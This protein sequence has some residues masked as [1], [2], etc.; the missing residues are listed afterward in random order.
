MFNRTSVTSRRVILGLVS[1][2]VVLVVAMAGFVAFSPKAEI[3]RYDVDSNNVALNGYDTVAYFVDGKATK[4]K[5][6]FEHLWQDAR[7]HF[8]NATNRDMFSANPNRFAPQYGG[9]CSVGLA[10]GEYS[11]ANPEAWSIVDGKLYL[12]KAKTKEIKAKVARL[13]AGKD[14]YIRSADYNWSKNRDQLR[15]NR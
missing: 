7:W 15:D 9:Y 14:Y 8:A 1:V 6:E 4:G 10:A 5:S 3:P 11:K 2:G 13:R 12:R